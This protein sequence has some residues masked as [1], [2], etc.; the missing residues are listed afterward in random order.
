MEDSHPNSTTIP[1]SDSAPVA[2]QSQP[3]TP[4]PPPPSPTLLQKLR[5]LIAR[6]LQNAATSTD[7]NLLRLSALLSTPTG[8]DVVLCTTGYTL[9]LVYAL[10]QQVLEKQLATVASNLASKA[11]DVMMPGETLIAD[12]PASASTKLLAQTVGSSKAIA[13]V[14]A[15]YR[16]FVRMWGMLGLYTWARDT[17]LAPLPKEAPRKERLLRGTTWA[18]IASCVLF[19]VLEN[20]AYA[21][22]KGMLTS[23]AWSGEVGKKRETLW[24]VW[25]SRFW[26]AYVG[27]EIVRLLIERAYYEPLVEKI[28]DG[29][30]E[31]KLRAEQEKREHHNKSFT[32]WKDL[33]SNIAYAPMT[34][35]WSVEAGLMS[36]VQVGVCGMIA[37]GAMLADAWRKTA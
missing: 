28:G 32:W 31:D 9:T 10:G 33:V 15:D 4:R 11:A 36:D 7:R 23:A 30:K 34:L 13:D 1:S 17:Y 20:G 2:P 27:C 25:S 21:S 35:H 16:I 22:S 19:Q 5:Y 8:I 6:R 29:E 3:N 37:G 12:L 26:A 24:W 14:I 18:A